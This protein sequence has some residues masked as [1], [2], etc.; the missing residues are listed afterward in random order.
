MTIDQMKKM[1]DSCYLA[2]RIRDM[3]P[4]LPQGVTPSYI[5][6]LDVIQKLERQ[7]GDVKVSDISD[8]LELPRPG[9]TRTV[10]EMESKGYLQKTTSHEDGRIT[11]ITITEEGMQLSDKYDRKYYGE[12][13]QYLGGIP[14]EDA[15]ITI[16]TLKKIYQIMSE[17]RI[18]LE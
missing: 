15:E 7:K 10:K 16:Q 2:K 1:M 12:L 8:A 18:N 3:M 17:R 14:E 13:S 11:Y 4:K 6:Y 9:V 5:Q